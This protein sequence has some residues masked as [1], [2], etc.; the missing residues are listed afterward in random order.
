M[1]DPG[2]CQ[3]AAV[4]TNADAGRALIDEVLAAIGRAFH[5]EDQAIG[6]TNTSSIRSPNSAAMRKAS[7]SEGS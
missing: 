2:R 1:L 5:W 4:M 6:A 7:G 3:G